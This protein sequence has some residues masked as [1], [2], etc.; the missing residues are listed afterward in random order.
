M[1]FPTDLNPAAVKQLIAFATGADKDKG[2][3]ALAAYDLVGYGL[4]K[5]L[6][7]TVY[8]TGDLAQTDANV[9]LV[10]AELAGANGERIKELL[11]KFGPV[12]LNALLKLLLK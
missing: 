6:G 9:A 2:R 1:S 4:G 8:L 12:I 5:I 7:N 10:E 11:Q 3:A